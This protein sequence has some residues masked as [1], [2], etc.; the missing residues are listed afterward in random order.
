MRKKRTRLVLVRED[1]YN[2]E[3]V[4]AALAA[5]E[6]D[7]DRE[8]ARMRG[9][10]S[11]LTQLAAFSG[12]SIS[13]SGGL[14]AGVLAGGRLDEGYLISLGACTGLAG[15]LLLLG[16]ITAFRALAPKDYTGVDETGVI[17]RTTPN[18]FRRRPEEA[19]AKVSASR[20]EALIAARAINDRKATS[21]RVVYLFVGSGFAALV[22][23]LIFTAVASVV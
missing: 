7:L 22:A 23:G 9:L 3:T 13:I 20:R 6:W 10:D 5:C 17:E 19:M 18:G 8:E 1:R 11:K 2:P 21:A 4:R 16:V 12:V 14:G 15:V